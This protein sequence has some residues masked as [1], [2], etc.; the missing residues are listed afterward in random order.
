MLSCIG[1]SRAPHDPPT[2]RVAALPIELLLHIFELILAYNDTF[3][4]YKTLR[5]ASLVCALWR[6]GAQLVLLKH[7]EVVREEDATKLAHLLKTIHTDSDASPIETLAIGVEGH[8]HFFI[9][10]PTFGALLGC[11]PRLQ[12]LIVCHTNS[13]PDTTFYHDPPHLS[14]PS[15]LVDVTLMAVG[16]YAHDMPQMALIR[17]LPESVKFLQILLPDPPNP[18]KLIIPHFSLYGLTIDV[19]PSM[20]TTLILLQSHESL[21]CLTVWELADISHLA[22]FQK[23]LRS[24]KVLGPIT[25]SGSLSDLKDLERLEL[26]APNLPNGVL[27]SIP[28]ALQYLRFGSTA[29]AKKLEGLLST[30][31]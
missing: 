26:R 8:S 3:T 12:K 15:N 20:M 28:D 14:N 27:E 1:L 19:Y 5:N 13:L 24:L 31:R 23:N 6:R 2:A 25:E 11:V 17:H 22:R 21:Q 10:R 30:L 9:T 16:S 7:I 4:S 29:L 18:E